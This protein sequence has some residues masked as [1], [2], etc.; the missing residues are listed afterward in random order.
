M[1]EES[2]AVEAPAPTPTPEA[3]QT[4]AAE[5]PK[6]EGTLVGQATPVEASAKTEAEAPAPVAEAADYSK[7]ALPEGFVPDETALGK[8][9]E[10]AGANK[11]PLETA[12]Q[13][14]SL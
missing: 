8:F 12:Q 11:L 9:R 13:M 1:A 4:T 2:A 10:V 14:L 5:T 7:L 3:T 6:P